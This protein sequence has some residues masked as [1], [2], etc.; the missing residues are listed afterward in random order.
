[1]R[2]E[3][4]SQLVQSMT[5]EEGRCVIKPAALCWMK[6]PL[7]LIFQHL[8]QLEEKGALTWHESGGNSLPRKEVWLK[9]GGDKGGGSFKFCMQIVNRKSP[10]SADNT[11]VLA[12]L[13]AADSLSNMHLTMDPFKEAIEALN[14]MTWRYVHDFHMLII[15]VSSKCSL[16]VFNTLI[17]YL[18]RIDMYITKKVKQCSF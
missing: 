10:N 6:N 4:S 8:S 1:M 13:M 9:F 14:G 11:A 15:S 5:T 3:F 12:C 17:M 16:K 7:T 2:V 18:T